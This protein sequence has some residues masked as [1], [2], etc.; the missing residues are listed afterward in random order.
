M[1]SLGIALQNRSLD[2]VKVRTLKYRSARR[3]EPWSVMTFFKTLQNEKLFVQY[4]FVLR[5]MKEIHA[6]TSMK[7]TWVS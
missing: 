1:D 7:T 6:G 3:T 4:V 5:A 2:V